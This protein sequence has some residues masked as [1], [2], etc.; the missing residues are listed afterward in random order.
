MNRLRLIL[1]II[2]VLLSGCYSLAEDITPPPGYVYTTPVPSAVP[3]EVMYFPFMPPDPEAGASI[4]AEKCEPCHGSAGLGDGP[5]A[6]ELPNPVAAIGDPALARTRTPE[7]WFT[8]VTNGNIE[9]YMP[10]FTSLTERQ[11]WDVVAY[12]FSLSVSQ[13]T[14]DRGAAVYAENCSA[15]HGPSGAGDGPDAAGLSLSPGAFND[16]ALMAERSLDDLVAGIAHPD[17]ADMAGAAGDLSVSD[18]LAVAA[19]VR[20][21]SFAG[22]A[23]AQG[24]GY[25]APATAVPAYPAPTEAPTGEAAQPPATGA[26]VVSGQ[27]IKLA[28]DP[29]PQGLEVQLLAFDNFQQTLTRTQTI[30]SD[31]MF[32]FTDVEM[33]EGRAFLV[34]VEFGRTT[35]TSDL[36]VAGP[37]P[38]E[39]SLQVTVYDATADTS[40]LSIDRMHLFFEFLSTDTVRVAELILITNPTDQ[41]VIADEEGSPT[42]EISLPPGAQNLQFEEGA[43]GEQFVELPGGFGDL[44]GIQPGIGAHQILFSFDM[45]YERTFDLNQ[46][47][48]LPVSAL[49]VLLPDVGVS[50]E[51]EGLTSSG[52]RDIE[53][54]TYE[55]FTGGELAAGSTLPVRLTGT[56]SFGDAGAVAGDSRNSLAIGMTALGLVFVG[57]GIWL[58]RR[59]RSAATAYDDEEDEEP[60]PEHIHAMSAE[61][62]M[63][64]IISLDDRYKVG[65]LPESAYLKQ[66]QLLKQQLGDVLSR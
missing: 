4:Y 21:L 24:A 6:A 50:L 52:T 49:V 25:P 5:K 62:L 47:V 60:V 55:L 15:C 12:A 38:Q 32:A 65:D 37:E 59:Q 17:V 13:E 34:A 23:L 11:R 43:L 30:A 42:V 44:R 35:Y 48:D 27:V 20:T 46:T 36:A 40:A 3:T 2:A 61:E 26:G 10:P 19:F 7:D 64:A 56:P 31:G 18:Q 8:Q 45:P 29:L 9:R 14:L 66:R 63:D 57:V 1:P 51:G 39:I 16:Q 41:M 58:Y 28:G 33:P 54:R 22:A 53:G